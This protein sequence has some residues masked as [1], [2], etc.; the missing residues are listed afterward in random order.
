M[1]EAWE[2]A[3]L[4]APGGFI[5]LTGAVH[6]DGYFEGPV[7]DWGTVVTEATLAFYDAHLKDD[8]DGWE[9]VRAAV[10]DGG[11]EVATLRER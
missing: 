8:P 5:N 4:D 6:D 1:T 9:R 2:E 11:P 10:T 3:A 7:D